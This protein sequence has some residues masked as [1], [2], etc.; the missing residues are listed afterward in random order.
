M[1]ISHTI[2]RGHMTLDLKAESKSESDKLARIIKLLK[3][4]SANYELILKTKDT[5]LN[6]ILFFRNK[7]AKLGFSLKFK[8]CLEEI[9]EDMEIQEVLQFLKNQEKKK[10][11]LKLGS[12]VISKNICKE[13]SFHLELRE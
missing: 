4:D 3:S 5:G 6:I 13:A 2:R 1:K 10:A 7:S 8:T 11:Y 12:E 9:E